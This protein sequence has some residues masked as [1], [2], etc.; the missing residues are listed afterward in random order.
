[1]STIYF[2]KQFNYNKLISFY[3]K[4]VFLTSFSALI[5]L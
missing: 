3:K 2:K 1:M 5:K 4:F